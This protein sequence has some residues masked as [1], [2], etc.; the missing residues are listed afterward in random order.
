MQAVRFHEHGNP[1]EVL[2]VEEVPLPQP[3]AGEVLVRMLATPINPSD[4]QY[5]EGRYTQTADLPAI[6]GF[7]GVGIVE[8]A[9]PG[10]FGK[11]LVGRRVVAVNRHGGN[12]ADYAVIPARQAIPVP[13]ALELEQA[14]TFFVNP[15]TAFVMT[16]KVLNVPRGDWLLQSAAGSALGRMIIRLGRET[17]FRTLNVVRRAAQ[18]EELRQLGGDE[19]V[20]FDGDSDNPDDLVKQVADVTGGGVRS[21]LDPVG[22]VVGSTLIRCLAARGRLLSFGTLTREPLSIPPRRL[23]GACA[24]VEGFALGRWME[25]QSLP[26]KIQLMRQVGN[27]IRRGILTSRIEERIALR[28]VPSALQ[29]AGSGKRLIVIGND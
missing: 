10:L 23:I 5:V 17:G 4:V 21:A 1:S 29:T 22:G 8:S 7:E 26:S 27:L 13:G 19:V 6:P 15:T 11:L 18:I 16:R 12:W 9:G 28:D 20:V 14:A 25:E 2:R 24:S 3:G